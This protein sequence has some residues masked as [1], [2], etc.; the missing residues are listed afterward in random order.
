MGKTDSPPGLGLR[1]ENDYSGLHFKKN[2]RGGIRKKETTKTY[3]YEKKSGKIWGGV[4]D[5]S[6]KTGWEGKRPQIIQTTN[7]VFWAGLLT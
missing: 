5:Q 7:F 3:Y 6:C 1:K 4:K 2:E